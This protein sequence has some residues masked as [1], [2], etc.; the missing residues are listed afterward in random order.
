VTAAGLTPYNLNMFVAKEDYEDLH[1][2]PCPACGYDL[3]G[4]PDE[5]RCPEC[6]STVH[7][8]AVIS[9]MCQWADARMLDL[10][11]IALLQTIGLLSALMA[12]AAMQKGQY[13]ALVL[14]LTGGVY[15]VAATIWFAVSGVGV[16]HRIRQPVAPVLGRRR[17]GRLRRWTIADGVLII[18]APILFWVLT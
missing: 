3:R 1:A 6:G 16:W 2:A 4:H 10:W 7:V 18:S 9:E 8:S 11:S 13:V 14:G 5:T 15:M 12:V 17:L